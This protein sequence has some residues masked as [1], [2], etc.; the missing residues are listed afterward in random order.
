MRTT[1]IAVVGAGPAGIGAALAA[2]RNGAN[3]ALIDENVAPGG[4][5]RW[6]MLQQTGFGGSPDG[7]RGFEIAAWAVDALATAGVQVLT[8]SVAWGLFEDNVLGVT[9]DDESIQL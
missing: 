1:D 5:L 7:P 2:A 8:S 3:V 9:T 6:T 4:H